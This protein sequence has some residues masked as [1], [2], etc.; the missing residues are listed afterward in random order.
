MKNKKKI[1]YVLSVRRN[2]DENVGFCVE[3]AIVIELR[4]LWIKL[5][6]LFSKRVRL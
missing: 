1:Y 4:V 3:E 6:T 5:N 2:N